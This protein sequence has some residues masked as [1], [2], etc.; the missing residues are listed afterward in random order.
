MNNAAGSNPTIFY[1]HTDMLGSTRIVTD[2]NRSIV[3]S[4]NYQPYGQD[5]LVS[6]SETYKFTG[7]PV[8]AT[9]GLY[10]FYHRWY[11]SSI[12]RFISQDQLPGSA[13]NPQSLNRYAYV[14][15]QPTL[16][17]DPTGLLS[18]DQAKAAQAVQLYRESLGDRVP[19]PQWLLDLLDE[20]AVAADAV[21]AEVPDSLK[22]PTNEEASQELASSSA[23]EA[24]VPNPNGRLGDEY[25]QARTAEI[26]AN[27]EARGPDSRTEFRIRSAE[28]GVNR[29]AD[30]AGIDRE[31]GKAVRSV[32]NRGAN[33]RR[34]SGI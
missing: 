33:A 28:P 6:G 2:K 13:L 9:T 27:V 16:L 25:T 32:S 12:G 19:L 29:F 8:S 3:F 18:N 15:N 4:D 20:P 11:D 1:Y 24:R 26:K 10:Y 14:L 7:K 21:G 23:Q 17:T 30:A 5:N 22:I 34:L 31:T